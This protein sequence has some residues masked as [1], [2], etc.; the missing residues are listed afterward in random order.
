MSLIRK[1][2]FTI[3]L[4]SATGL[5]LF[6]KN[7]IALCQDTGRHTGEPVLKHSM[8]TVCK[9][10]NVPKVFEKVNRQSIIS[11]CFP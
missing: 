1:V 7:N 11:R 6:N 8:K 9:S 3:A 10:Y 2:F 5:Q 4:S